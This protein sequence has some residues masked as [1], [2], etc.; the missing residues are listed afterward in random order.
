MTSSLTL[1]LSI[2]SGFSLGVAFFMAL[3]VSSLLYLSTRF[4]W[5]GLLLYITRFAITIW[6]FWVMAGFGAVPLLSGFG[7]FLLG[8]F[9][10][11]R[12]LAHKIQW[13]AE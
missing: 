9:F 8:R 4:M 5:G 2:I 10:V 1:I 6:V 11:L 12:V 13:K 3:K 7:C